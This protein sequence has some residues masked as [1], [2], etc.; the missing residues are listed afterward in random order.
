MRR[1]ASEI[2]RELETRIARLESKKA[3]LKP[4]SRGQ[5]TTLDDV[6]KPIIYIISFPNSMGFTIASIEV[7]GMNER[8]VKKT[9]RDI[10]ISISNTMRDMNDMERFLSVQEH[11]TMDNA[12]FFSVDSQEA[13]KEELEM[14]DGA[15]AHF[16]ISQEIYKDLKKEFPNLIVI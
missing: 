14:F 9:L 10:Q 3:N 13:T 2:I 5:G 11:P 16:L 6:F 8:R 15:N 4:L 1:S 7:I 12:L